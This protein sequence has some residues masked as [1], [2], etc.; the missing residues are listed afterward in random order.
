MSEASRLTLEATATQ[1]HM[2]EHN[3]SAKRILILMSDT[4]GGHRTSAEA[5]RAAFAGRYGTAFH[6]DI[7][8]MWTKHTPWPLNQLPK[9][10][11]FLAND[12]PWLW[13]LLWEITD[14]PDAT[15][16]VMRAAYRWAKR[17]VTQFIYLYDPDLIISVHP[18]LQEVP[19]RILARMKRHIPFVTVI[20][21]L[22][23]IHPTWFQKGAARCFV[24]ND[25]VYH[26]ALESGLQPEQ[27]RMC[28]F[29]VRPVFAQESRPK[30][31]VRREL[32]LRVD[33]PLAL[34]VGGGE[35][36]GKVAE[37]ARAVAARLASDGAGRGEPAGQLVI[38]CGRNRKL[39]EELES[40]TWPVP[41]V[42]QGFVHNMP[43]WMAASDCIVTKAGPNTISEALTLGLPILLTGFIAGQEEG[44][45]PYVVSNEVGLY[46]E[47]PEGAA[48]IVSRWFG[49]ERA[50]LE[51]MAQKA[52]QMSRP[53]A[54]F[55]VVEEIAALLD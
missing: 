46:C 37:I 43:D 53:Q 24:P 27:V 2:K 36:I 5:L 8:D 16:P 30:E 22:L 48:R 49:P 1:P 7:V 42:V 20:T 55:Q 50:T 33:L 15:K 39:R 34:L 28:G 4:G 11:R 14:K 21:D 51:S 23:S 45:I 47:D 17:R 18:L 44:N 19:L 41:T 29:P 12:A 26:M 13:K 9:S 10:Y 40:D 6:V 32:G 35:G 52:H 25:T 31:V 54:I 38:I 3:P